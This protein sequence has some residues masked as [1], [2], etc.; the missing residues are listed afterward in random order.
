MRSKGHSI[1]ERYLMASQ[2]QQSGRE[3]Y[4]DPTDVTINLDPY[5]DEEYPL[6]VGRPDKTEYSG[7]HVITRSYEKSIKSDLSNIEIP[8]N[9]KKAANCI[10]REINPPTR[11]NMRR[12]YLVLYAIMCAYDR[13][14]EVY[15]P[16]EISEKAGVPSKSIN[17][18]LSIDNK[19]HMG[20]FNR[21]R[22]ADEYVP[23]YYKRTGLAMSGM[24]S[25]IGITRRVMNNKAL[26]G[27]FPQKVAIGCTLYYMTIM[28]S[29]IDFKKLA[30]LF[31]RS[32]NTLK[33]Y[34]KTVSDADNSSD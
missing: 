25:V 28:E 11:R 33:A 19:Y 5:Y 4:Y 34:L 20:N 12:K 1:A 15:D 21:M 13:E 6:Y 18:A 30:G 10:Y 14:D 3:L 27:E 7:R 22:T 16:I 8:D 17:K 9:I 32:E 24:S 2:G 29:K 31:Y 23:M 26:R